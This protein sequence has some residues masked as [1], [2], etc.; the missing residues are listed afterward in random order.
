MFEKILI[1]NRGEIACRV[2]RTCRQLGIKTVAVYSQADKKALHVSLADEAYCL[3]PAAPTQSYL[4]VAKI[5]EVAKKSGAQAIHPGYGFLSENAEFAE[6]LSEENITFIG[7]SADAIRAMGEKNKA[8]MLMEKAGV[9]LVPGYHGSDQS[10]IFLKQ[11]ADKMDYP[12]LIKASAG[13]G[14]KGM[15]LVEKAEEF[16]TALASAKRTARSAFGND[17]V[18]LERYVQEPRHVEIQVFGDNHG[19]YV[20]LFERDCSIQRRHQKI[21]EEAPAPNITEGLRRQMGEAAIAAAKAIN[22]TGAGTV[23]FLLD[24]KQEFYFM[25]MN[26]RL[27]VEHPVTEMITG[28]DLV[29]WQLLVAANE[30]LPKSQDELK[31]NGHAI[32]VRIYAED[33]SQDFLPSIG[34][35]Q[36]LKFPDHEQDIR[37]DTGVRQVFEGQG[38]QISMHYDPMIAKMIVWGEDRLEA[39]ANMRYALSETKLSGI[40]SNLMYLSSVTSHAAFIQGEFT[41]HF[42]EQYSDALQT[43]CHETPSETVLAFAALGILS[44]RA[45]KRECYSVSQT[46]PYSPWHDLSHWRGAHERQDQ[47]VF[48]NGKDE[49]TVLIDYHGENETEFC[50]TLPD[51]VKCHA[52]YLPDPY[53]NSLHVVL[54]DVAYQ[55]VVT[56]KDGHLT[57][58]C[59]GNHFELSWHDPLRGEELSHDGNS[60]LTAPMPGKVVAVHVSA[61]ASVD[62]GQPLVIIEAMKMEHTITAP[63]AGVIAAVNTNVG[64]QVDE[65]L[66]LVSFQ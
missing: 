20:Y 7:P 37:V 61:G 23:E 40:R 60:K 3:G 54:N 12:V 31:I 34:Q 53:D 47:L 48:G 57:I 25:E 18:L 24:K 35:I 51:N 66:E 50:L 45:D 63:E 13:G 44:Q 46:D 42:I 62:K 27:Q 26:T 49:Y 10:E 65:K 21:V 55:V 56:N 5:L 59:E 4:H 2:I 28:E 32:E 39:V 14:G 6:L 58:M 1:A 52:E 8:K 29:F 16:S 22:Y 33:P 17:E 9:P 11:Q 19:H 30:T 36:Y 41:T 15:V 64:D 43:G 38:D